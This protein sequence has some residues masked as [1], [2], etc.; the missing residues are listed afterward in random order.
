[1]TIDTIIARREAHEAIKPHKLT[2]ERMVLD[3]LAG[4]ELTA[5]E[6]A[7]VSGITLNNA[8][9]RLT[10]LKK[11]GLVETNGRRMSPVTG[12][13]TTIWKRKES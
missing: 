9:S 8:R 5:E 12:I 11:K 1:M 7:A 3:A 2:I 6:V 10:E 13:H 4:R